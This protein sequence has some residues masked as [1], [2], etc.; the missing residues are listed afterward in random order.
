MR[1]SV[2]PLFQTAL[3]LEQEQ[4]NDLDLGYDTTVL[5][6]GPVASGKTSV[7]QNIFAKGPGLAPQFATTATKSISTITG[8]VCGINM[9]FIDTPGQQGQSDSCVH[10]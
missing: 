10:V 2:D 4:G 8:S 7:I 6:L 5:V 1:P 9:T 3:D